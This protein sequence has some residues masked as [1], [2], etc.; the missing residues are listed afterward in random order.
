LRASL[1]LGVRRASAV[2]EQRGTLAAPL[3]HAAV[4][5]VVGDVQLLEPFDHRGIMA[6]GRRRRNG[7]RGGSSPSRTA[8]GFQPPAPRATFRAALRSPLP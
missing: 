8:P 5:E 6:R 4:E 1:Q 2:G 7:G 3:A